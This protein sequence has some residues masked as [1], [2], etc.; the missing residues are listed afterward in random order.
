MLRTS[1]SVALLLAFS[2]GITG[3]AQAVPTVELIWRASG[4]GTLDTAV[5]MGPEYIVDVVL[6]A[7][8]LGV[9]VVSMGFEFDADLADELDF[10]KGAEL[11]EVALPGMGN[12]FTPILPGFQT[13]TESTPSVVGLAEQFDMSSGTAPGLFDVDGP[14]TLGSMTFTVNTQ[15]SDGADI[16]PGFYTFGIDGMSKSGGGLV[17]PNFIPAIVP[18]PTSAAMGAI[19]LCALAA[20]GSRRRK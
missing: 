16:V 20:L 2:F 9:A 7:D 5:N 15:I 19:A 12:K 8:S 1:R 4:T 13:V 18:E 17:T 10:V 6:T 14:R 3:A 11:V